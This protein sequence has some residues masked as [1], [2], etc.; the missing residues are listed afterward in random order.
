MTVGGSARMRACRDSAA[1][2]MGWTAV[3]AAVNVGG[4][5]QPQRHR[6]RVWGTGRGCLKRL[7]TPAPVTEE[8]AG[9]REGISQFHD[10]DA[11]HRQQ[12]T[13][14]L[15]AVSSAKLSHRLQPFVRF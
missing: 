9:T 8:N 15:R 10:G 2:A 14:L 1:V 6:G 12:G 5:R 4:W 7:H 11:A 3:S 13:N